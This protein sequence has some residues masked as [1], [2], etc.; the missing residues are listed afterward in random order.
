M[1][2]DW[3]R[4][5][6]AVHV[7][8]LRGDEILLLRRFNTGYEDG[9]LS[10]V[11]GHVERGET[12]TQ[13]AIREGREEV[14]LSLAPDRV[15][16]VGVMH[17][18]SDDERI[19]FFLTYPLG[20]G[21]PR[22]LETDKCSELVWVRLDELPADTIPYVRAAIEQFRAGRWFGEFGWGDRPA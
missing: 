8:V 3:A 9:K 18:R 14:G 22:N 19:D 17:R 11:A 1:S 2:G 12:V 15:R 16:V 7:L 10:V 13:A 4:F 5:P 6:V 20:D 21:E